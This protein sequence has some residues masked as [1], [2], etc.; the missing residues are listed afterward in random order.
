MKFTR[1]STGSFRAKLS[2]L[3]KKFHYFFHRHQVTN[4]VSDQQQE[5]LELALT[6]D[7]IPLSMSSDNK[8]GRALS[9]SSSLPISIGIAAST[10]PTPLSNCATILTPATTIAVET[11]DKENILVTPSPPPPPPP[12]PQV[13]LLE[14]ALL[15]INENLEPHAPMPSK[16]KSMAVETE[17]D[18][19][20]CSFKTSEW[21]DLFEL[22]QEAVKVFCPL[23]E[24]QA[25]A[26]PPTVETKERYQEVE[27]EVPLF[28]PSI[29]TLLLSEYLLVCRLYSADQER[30][31]SGDLYQSDACISPGLSDYSSGSEAYYRGKIP[32]NFLRLHQH[33]KLIRKRTRVAGNTN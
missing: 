26:S 12:P 17:G 8:A 13:A 7:V 27:E 32:R 18:N 30:I 10:L 5:I 19:N 2:S 29:P 22:Y 3:G 23:I 6:S 33:P 25:A 21:K 24:P 31:I 9:T 15:V 14:K 16:A 28:D 20:D 4:K 11:N 1:T